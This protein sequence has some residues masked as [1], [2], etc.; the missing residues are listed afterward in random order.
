MMK[1][2]NRMSRYLVSPFVMV[3]LLVL[4]STGGRVVAQTMLPDQELV[5]KLKAGG[6]NLY[7]RHEATDWSQN[8]QVNRAQDWLS[9]D[10]NR[11]RQLSS[12]GRA[13]AEATGKAIRSLGIPVS[14][15][16]ASPYCRTVETARL[17]GLGTVKPTTEVMNLRVAEYFGGR[18]AIVATA[19]ALLATPP[20]AGSNVVIVAH[21]NVA[22]A[23]TPVYPG[24]G[25]GVV[26]KPDGNGGFQFVGRLT[27]ADWVRLSNTSQ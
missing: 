15:V 8:D 25:E 12:K 20:R 22:Q 23:A 1:S 24:E 21:G 16:L 9:C 26:F 2:V 11:M 17:M 27:P 3:L 5:A 18:S 4:V 10:G 19:R 6:Y 14:Q 7:F 13:N